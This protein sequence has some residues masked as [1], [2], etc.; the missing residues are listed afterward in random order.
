MQRGPS[1]ST[2]EA[3]THFCTQVTPLH[4][5]LYAFCPQRLINTHTNHLRTLTRVRGC[6]IPQNPHI[7][8]HKNEISHE[9]PGAIVKTSINGLSGSRARARTHSHQNP[10]TP[11]LRGAHAPTRPQ[12][13]AHS[14]T[15]GVAQ[16]H[17]AHAR[18]DAR[19]GTHSRLARSF[20]P[21]C[22]RA[23]R[24]LSPRSLGRA[25]GHAH[26]LR[27]V[28]VTAPRPSPRPSPARSGWAQA[29]HSPARGRV[30][31]LPAGDWRAAGGQWVPH[32]LAAP[33]LHARRWVPPPPARGPRARSRPSPPRGPRRP[34]CSCALPPQAWGRAG[35]RPLHSRVSLGTHSH[36][37][38][39]ETE[40]RL[41]L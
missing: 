18:S 32:E 12:A 27:P 24:S 30:S 14:R 40:A 6:T 35:R 33:R 4:P 5:H 7:L 38:A 36:F 8:G 19:P 28:W 21:T 39:G 22:P 16:G 26:L 20:A 2:T 3:L 41:S 15:H 13:R 1:A 17:A 31:R 37:K 11:T 10:T 23:H 29:G 25:G 9:A 34:L